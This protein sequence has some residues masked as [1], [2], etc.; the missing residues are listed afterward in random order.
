MLFDS[1]CDN[2]TRQRLPQMCVCDTCSCFFFPELTF[3][4]IEGIFS[5]RILQEDIYLKTSF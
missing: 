4:L 1:P 5:Q 3:H 2:I